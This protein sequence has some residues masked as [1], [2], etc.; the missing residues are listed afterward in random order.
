M[1]HSL[2]M[3]LRNGFRFFEYS[4]V[5]SGNKN[6][7]NTNETLHLFIRNGSWMTRTSDPLAFHLFGTD[8]MPLPFTARTPSQEV[9]AYVQESKPFARLTIED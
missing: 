4:Q 9:L 3:S 1:I 8:C 6:N 7:M 2:V 5:K